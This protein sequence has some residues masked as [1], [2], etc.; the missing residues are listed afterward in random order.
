MKI[1]KPS[2]AHKIPVGSI[3]LVKPDLSFDPTQPATVWEVFAPNKA[4]IMDEHYPHGETEDV[5]FFHPAELAIV[6]YTN[7][8]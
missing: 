6:G 7:P 8:F 3:I 4:V 5:D 2:E 1:V